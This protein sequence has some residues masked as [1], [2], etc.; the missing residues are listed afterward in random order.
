MSHLN[1]SADTEKQLVLQH[2]F[3]FDSWLPLDKHKI[4]CCTV[5]IVDQLIK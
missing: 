1:L 5:R 4:P 2:K 3:N